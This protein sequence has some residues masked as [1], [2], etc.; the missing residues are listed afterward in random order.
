MSLHF[1]LSIPLLDGLQVPLRRIAHHALRRSLN[2]APHRTWEQLRRH[3]PPMGSSRPGQGALTS[4]PWGQRSCAEG[5][6]G[7]CPSRCAVPWAI[8]KPQLQPCAAFLLL[9]PPLFLPKPL[10][11]NF[12]QHAPLC[13]LH[14]PFAALG[15]KGMPAVAWRPKGMSQAVTPG[16]GARRQRSQGC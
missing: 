3:G 1:V 10:A 9:F 4:G 16:R 8:A 13:L 2:S 6:P 7:R 15:T 12:L 14:A 5:F 11:E